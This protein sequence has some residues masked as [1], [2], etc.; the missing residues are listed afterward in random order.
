[1]ETIEVPM[2]LHFKVLFRL[3]HTGY[4]VPDSFQLFPTLF[5]FGLLSSARKPIVKFLYLSLPENVKYSLDETLLLGRELVFC[6]LSAKMR[7]RLSACARQ[8][9][10]CQG[11]CHDQA[12][13]QK[14]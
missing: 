4:E 11:P 1:M 2:R 6:A 9:C 12:R 3:V 10:E 13:L 5:S 14:T 8:P 7:L